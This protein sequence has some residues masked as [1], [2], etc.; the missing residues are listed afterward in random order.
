MLLYGAEERIRTS[1]LL[2]T[3]QLLYQLSYFGITLKNAA[4]IY[5]N[6]LEMQALSSGLI[7]YPDDDINACLHCIFGQLWG[8]LNNHLLIIDIL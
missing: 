7:L 3:K 1:D 4:S 6:C 2:F 5:P 8:R